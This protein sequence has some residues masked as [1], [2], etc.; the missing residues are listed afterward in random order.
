[1]SLVERVDECMICVCKCVCLGERV[2]VCMCVVAYVCICKWVCISVYRNACCGCYLYTCEC[3]IFCVL[4]YCVVCI[5]ANIFVCFGVCGVCVFVCSCLYAC[6]CV[7]VQT[8]VFVLGL[9]APC[10]CAFA[11]VC[12]SIYLCVCVCV[13]VRSSARVS[14]CVRSPHA[15]T[16]ARTAPS[17]PE[18]R[19]PPGRRARE[20]RAPRLSGLRRRHRRR[21][22]FAL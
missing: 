10:E 11:C 9:C 8:Q 17:R 5:C 20:G 7:I 13:R 18:Q 16:S 3:I 1:M 6:E 4:K 22:D 2:S 12:E 15:S 14:G 19:Q 21:A